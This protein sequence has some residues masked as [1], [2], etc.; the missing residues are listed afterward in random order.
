MSLNALKGLCSPSPSKQLNN[1]CLTPNILPDPEHVESRGTLFYQIET[2][3]HFT[4]VQQ[5]LM[6]VNLTGRSQF[7]ETG[8]E[9]IMISHCIHISDHVFV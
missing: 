6:R 9:E 4:G 5:Q 8:V 7:K 3:C 2:I 1:S